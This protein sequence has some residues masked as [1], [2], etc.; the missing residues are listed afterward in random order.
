MSNVTYKTASGAQV[1]MTLEGSKMH[2]TANGKPFN[3]RLAETDTKLGFVIR[4]YNGAT[5]TV[6]AE[7][8]EQ[9]K[10]ICETH[11]KAIVAAGQAEYADSYESRARD[12]A[13]QIARIG[14][15]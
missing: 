7:A 14:G 11:R 15:N 8:V 4:T 6:P 13:A 9:V 1:S 3:F 2:L 5:I 10:E 12:V